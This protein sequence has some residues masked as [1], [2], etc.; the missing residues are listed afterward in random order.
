MRASKAP[1][2]G[3]KEFRDLDGNLFRLGSDGQIFFASRHGGSVFHFP[4]F[5]DGRISRTGGGEIIR[6]GR[7]VDVINPASLN[8]DTKVV[9]TD[10]QPE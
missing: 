1:A 7:E 5:E 2:M 9:W 10:D 4:V 3:R 6:P 8:M